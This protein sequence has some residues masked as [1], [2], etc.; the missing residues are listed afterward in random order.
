MATACELM[1]QPSLAWRVGDVA[2]E[3]AA[4][5]V[6]FDVDATFAVVAAYFVQA[7]GK[8]MQMSV[9]MLGTPARG[10]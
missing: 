8:A 1:C 5:Y 6:G 2:A 9:P 7:L 10:A 3:V 4:D